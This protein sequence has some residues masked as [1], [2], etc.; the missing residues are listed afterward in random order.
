MADRSGI[1][2]RPVGDYVNRMNLRFETDAGIASR[3]AIGLVVLSSDETLEH[4][5][6]QIVTLPGCAFHIA[7]VKNDPRITPFT[8]VDMESRIGAA[9]GLIL[10][11][12]H[13]D[14]V[15]YACTSATVVMG[16]EAVFG[17]LRKAR[18]DA[19]RTTPITA[20]FAAFD[21]FAA[22]RIA[23]LSPYRQDVNIRLRQYIETAGYE[24][25]VMGS[26][27]E[28]NDYVVSRINEDSVRRAVV[29]LGQADEVDAV[30][31][32]CTALRLSSSVR[33]LEEEIGKPVT[34]SNHALAWHCLRLSG[35]EDIQ[36]E[37]G[38]LFT[39]ALSGT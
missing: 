38:R 25:P 8:V 23:I 33:E 15:A 27:S 26:F 1:P 9:A 32:S 3:A 35:V 39:L 29:E 12:G 21:S 30:F 24:V 31:V 28:E 11:G 10:P 20:A 37:F 4:E 6:R 18:P 16:E 34:S 5:F 36:P 19:A 14:V 2:E 7:R 22:S 17:Q 13:L